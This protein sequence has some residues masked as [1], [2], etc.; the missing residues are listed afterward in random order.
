MVPLNAINKHWTMPTN[1]CE[2]EFQ[3]KRLYDIDFLYVIFFLTVLAPIKYVHVFVFTYICTNGC[4]E[5]FQGKRLY[6]FLAFSAPIAQRRSPSFG[7]SMKRDGRKPES[8]CRCLHV[9][10][11]VL[12]IFAGFVTVNKRIRYNAEYQPTREVLNGQLR[13]QVRC[14]C[15]PETIGRLVSRGADVNCLDPLGYTPLMIAVTADQL[16][17]N[18]NEII[19][20]LC[21]LGA[22]VNYTN[23]LFFMDTPLHIAAS[24]KC[25]QVAK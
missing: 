25:E 14:G 19:T 4:K 23:D 24:H 20:V 1:R 5:E 8:P 6:D 17:D 7:I 10:L 9:M 16:L 2:E 11:I 15:S 21:E 12:F 18:K 13:I 22:D 3:G